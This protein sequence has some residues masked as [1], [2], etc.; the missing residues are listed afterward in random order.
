MPSEWWTYSLSDFLLFSSRTYYRLFELQNAALWPAQIA[1]LFGGAAAA[2]LLRR[3]GRARS[4][5]AAV[6]LAAAWGWVAWGYFHGRYAAINL[7]ADG[8]AAAF[9]LQAAL[10][11]LAAALGTLARPARG[12]AGAI[13]LGLVACALAGWPLIAPLAGRPW[14][15]AEVF[16][17]APDPTAIATLGALLLASPRRWWLLAIPA[18]WCLVTGATLWTMGSP[19]AWLA[20]AA[21]AVALAAAARRR[22]TTG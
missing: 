16:G 15:Q 19:E 10:L 6:L 11:L 5:I 2:A 14:R 1:G 4:G 13:G 17:L 18:A 9:A 8:Y 7:V 20:P 21:A 12:A 3:G 22:G